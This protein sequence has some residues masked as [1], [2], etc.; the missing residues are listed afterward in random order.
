MVVESLKVAVSIY[1]TILWRECM[2]KYQLRLYNSKIMI[3]K[4]AKVPTIVAGI[5]VKID[6]MIY[7]HT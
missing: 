6:T 4:C 3:R 1:L 7:K 2:R 5:D